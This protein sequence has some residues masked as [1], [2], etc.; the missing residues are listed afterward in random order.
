MSHE[1]CQN[2]EGRAARFHLCGSIVLLLFLLATLL[3]FTAVARG[4][5]GGT[6]P[7]MMMM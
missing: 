1:S 7:W 3:L 2:E 5:I 6:H 4:W